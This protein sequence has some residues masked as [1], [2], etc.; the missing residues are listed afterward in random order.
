[1]KYTFFHPPTPPQ[2][3][4]LYPFYNILAN[5]L[6][7]FIYTNKILLNLLIFQVFHK[8]NFLFHLLFIRYKNSKSFFLLFWNL[9]FLFLLLLFCWVLQPTPSTLCGHYYYY[10]AKILNK[11]DITNNKMKKKNELMLML[12]FV[13]HWL[14]L[15]KTK[16]QWGRVHKKTFS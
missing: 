10:C 9:F 2:K 4:N 7:Y 3:K 14:N 16:K 13:F 11:I 8:K 6:F 12:S 1:M 15:Q 5:V